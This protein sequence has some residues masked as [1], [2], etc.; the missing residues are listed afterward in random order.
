M[1]ENNPNKKNLFNLSYLF[2]GYSI[3]FF[4]TIIRKYFPSQK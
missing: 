4:L 1:N 2:K 3:V